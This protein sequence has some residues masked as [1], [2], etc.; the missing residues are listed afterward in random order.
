MQES[1]IFQVA[2]KLPLS[3][4]DAFLESACKGDSLLR[5]DIVH[6]LQAHQLYEGS[7]S[8]QADS[9]TKDTRVESLHT[10]LTQ[11]CLF[12]RKY[13]VNKLLG[14]GGMGAVFLADQLEPVQRQVAI[15]IIRGHIA[16]P[17]M[18]ARFELEQR[19]LALMNHP[20]IARV[21]DAGITAQGSPYFVMEYIQGETLIRYFKSAESSMK[22]RLAIMIQICQAIHHAHQKGVIHRDLKPSNI[23]VTTVDGKPVPRIIDFGT[24]KSLEDKNLNPLVQTEFGA[25]VG[26]PEYMS[27]EQSAFGTDIDTR[28]DI[29][30]LGIILYEMLTETVPFPRSEF[31]KTGLSSMLQAIR[32]REPAKPSI[33]VMKRDSHLGSSSTLRSSSIQGDLDS[34]V[35]KALEK[36]R[37]NRYASAEAMAQ[38]LMRYLA[39]EPVLARP[40]SASYR[41]KK[42]VVKNRGTVVAASLIVL[43]LLTGLTGTTWA[44]FKAEEH[45]NA[46]SEAESVAKARLQQVEMEKR[47]TDEQIEISNS[48]ID[49][50]LVDVFRQADPAWQKL[51]G[52]KVV[53]QITL[54][55]AIQNAAKSIDGRFAD[56]P[57]QEAVIRR[58]VGRS[59]V[60]VGEHRM[61]VPHFKRAVE[62][63]EP[64]LDVEPSNIQLYKSELADV[65]VRTGNYREAIALLPEILKEEERLLGKDEK[66]TLDTLHRLAA[67]HTSL[68]QYPQARELWEKLIERRTRKYGKDNEYVMS[69]RAELAYVIAR[70]GNVPEAIKLLEPDYATAIKILPDDN[71]VVLHLS[72]ILA[73]CYNADGDHAKALPMYEKL[74]QIYTSLYG[75]THPET[76]INCIHTANC[77]RKANR[78]QD[79]IQLLEPVITPITQKFGDNHEYTLMSMHTLGAAY[80]VEDQ[81][82]KAIALLEKVYE[83]R[84]KR[85]GDQNLDTLAIIPDLALAYQKQGHANKAV[86]VY[87]KYQQY[88]L[89]KEGAQATNT[90][91]ATLH[92]AT[93]YQ[94]A[95]D[96]DKAVKL[97]APMMEE[98]KNSFR[99]TNQEQLTAVTRYLDSLERLGKPEQAEELRR[100]IST[101]LSN[102]DPDAQQL[103]LSRL[104]N[105][106]NMQKKYTEAEPYILQCMKLQQSSSRKPTWEQAKLNTIHADTLTGLRQYEPAEK[107]LHQGWQMLKQSNP[108]GEQKLVYREVQAD[109][110]HSCIQLYQAWNKPDAVKHWK[111]Q[112]QAISNNK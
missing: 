93:A 79:V 7:G 95:G 83:A 6:L 72:R 104:A 54:T 15:K 73:L 100:K 16:L 25:L 69:S 89:G 31:E 43:A 53:P 28:S 34:I 76:L 68:G 98:L 64:M 52:Q 61:A 106:L 103:A 59:L 33:A 51:R 56:K 50:F 92:L 42:F 107:L 112:L 30:S 101:D 29:Y 41:L 70:T 26:T 11:G 57:Y 87:E 40:A 66:Q 48:I 8:K 90:R 86:P 32:Q 81:D 60:K 35:M 77:L 97:L 111:E 10:Q 80:L 110:M 67:A 109:L 27:P 14:E 3:E 24:V 9:A 96:V 102:G 78:H 82:D 99:T 4:R 18:V 17:S 46:A 63:I 38:D 21:Y 23:L 84:R 55:D 108:K 19:A 2:R 88:W 5:Q 12:E 22:S 1:E 71:K 37:D 65:L 75:K 47:K 85:S 94:Y 36:D 49:F 62:L 39:D 45:A 58:T 105:N 44:M 74:E 91:K 13:R 20:G